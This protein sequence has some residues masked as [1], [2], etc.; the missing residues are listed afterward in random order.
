MNDSVDQIQLS[1][2][3]ENL[4]LLNIILGFIMFGVALELRLA[5]FHRLF[6]Q[7]KA[8]L[9]GM[10]SQFLFLPAATFALVYMMRPQPSIALGMLLVAACPGGNISNFI[11]LMARGNAALS[12]TLTAVAT[13]LAMFMTPLNFAFWGSLY[14]PASQILREIHLDFVD[15]FITISLIMGLPLV[16]GMTTAHYLPK[17]T[18]RMLR[19]IKVL[20]I[21]FFIGFVVVALGSN[22]HYFSEYI[23]YIVFIVLAHNAIAFLGGYGLARLAQLDNPNTRAIT[24]ETGIQNSGLALV[25]IF[26]F[27][28]GLGGMA[29]IA[30]WWGIWHIIAGLSLAAVWARVT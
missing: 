21:L 6:Q 17:W 14:P 5:D 10:V 15:M 18:A 13:V 2:S 1:F 28:N 22:F 16:L 7:P 27:F 29:I 12:V 26:G 19:P 23:H 24:I 9:V 4:F 30:A 11:S 3:P 8:P 25:I 20:S